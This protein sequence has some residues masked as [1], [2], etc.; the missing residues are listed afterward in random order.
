MTDKTVV[1]ERFHNASTAHRLDSETP[2]QHRLVASATETGT[3]RQYRE[4]LNKGVVSDDFVHEVLHHG[5]TE[6]IP[7][8]KQL[9][10]NRVYCG[11][12]QRILIKNAIQDA[13]G[14]QD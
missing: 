4:E 13:I 3:Q 2:G 6:G 9:D 1:E 8:W 12:D 14:V 11:D 7:L 10:M 5:N